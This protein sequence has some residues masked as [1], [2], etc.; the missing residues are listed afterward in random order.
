VFWPPAALFDAMYIGAAA[1]RKKHER[2]RLKG[3]LGRVVGG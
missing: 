1:V 2:A 3:A